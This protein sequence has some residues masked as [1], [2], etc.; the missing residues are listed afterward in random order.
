MHPLNP[1]MDFEAQLSFASYLGDHINASTAQQPDQ[2]GSLSANKPTYD[3][4]FDGTLLANTEDG[5][6]G[7]MMQHRDIQ[8]M[9]IRMRSLPC[10]IRVLQRTPD[11]GHGTMHSLLGGTVSRNIGK[12]TEHSNESSSATKEPLKDTQSQQD[13]ETTVFMRD[14]LNYE[15]TNPSPNAT[16]L[17]NSNLKKE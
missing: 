16:W 8:L 7:Q 5:K 4:N 11:D 9:N 14:L 10:R 3:S 2:V 12:S 13:G 6:A 15:I 17:V 1:E